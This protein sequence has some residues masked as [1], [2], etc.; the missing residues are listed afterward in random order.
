MTLGRMAGPLL[1]Q[2]PTRLMLA[3]R[4]IWARMRVMRQ[5]MSMQMR[6]HPLRHQQPPQ[7]Q[8]QVQEEQQQVLAVTWTA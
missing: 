5:L 7:Q 3:Q 4:G 8:Q 2:A 1:L 6:T